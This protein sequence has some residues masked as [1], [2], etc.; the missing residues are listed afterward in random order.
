MKA[1]LRLFVG[2]VLLTLI[3]SPLTAQESRQTL[4]ITMEDEVGG[5]LVA[6]RTTLLHV[7][8]GQAREVA[9]TREG[10]AVFTGLEPGEYKLSVSAPGFRNLERTITIGTESPRPMRLQMI[11][12]VTEVVEVEELTR[13]AP[14]REEIDQN[15]D[16]VN[17]NDD[18]LVGIPMSIRGDRIVTFLSRFMNTAAGLPSIVID[19]HEVTRLNLPP[20][21]IDELVVNKN[22]YSAEYRRP[23]RAR[24]EVVSQ[25]GS[26]SHHHGDATLIFNNSV[27]S[28]KSP[29]V[30]EKPSIEEMVGEFGFSGPLRNTKGSFLFAAELGGDRTTAVV[31]AQ[32]LDGPVIGFVPE[33]QRE[34]FYTGRIDLSPSD[35]VDLSMR[36]EYES[37][38]ERNGGVGGLIL[39]ELARNGD[40]VKHDVYLT[41]S[42]ILSAGFIHVPSIRLSRETQTEGVRPPTGPMIIVQGA[43]EGGVL[44]RYKD[45][46]I[47]QADFVD[48]AT[49]RKG[50]HVVRFGGRFTPSTT[51]MSDL[52]DFGGRYE[53]ASLDL[54]REGKPYTFTL[55]E[56][57]PNI[58]YNL[59]TAD[60]HLQDEFKIRPDFT[61][62]AGVRWDWESIL[63][64]NNNVSPRLA[65]SFAPGSKKTAIRGGAGMFY[66]RVGSTAWERVNLYGGDAIRSMVFDNP[67]YPDYRVGANGVRPTPTRYQL[68][69]GLKAPFMSQ[70]SIG[71]DRQVSLESSFSLEFVHLRGTDLFRVRDVNAPPPGTTVRPD[72]LYNR[73]VEIET[74]GRMRSNSVHATFNGEVGEFEGHVLYTY[75]KSD[76]DTPGS[77][78]GGVLS[79]TLPGDSFNPGSEWGPADWDRKHRFSAAGVYELPKELSVGFVLDWMSGLPYEITTGFD[80]NGDGLAKDHPIGVGRNAGRNPTFFQLDMRVGKM[81]TSRRPVDQEEEPA[82]FELFI[83][84]FNVFNT[85]NYSDYVGVRSSPN[86]GL[87]TRAEKGRQLQA[88]FSYSF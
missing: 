46:E 52:N 17:V 68:A 76:N 53:F 67:T 66:E 69:Q 83:D 45:W 20:R 30:N 56:G 50:R 36:Y 5:V 15:A 14:E 25:D 29:F 28:A 27:V 85:I 58:R 84:V 12:E 6:V 8:S 24:I 11:V 73:V 47:L 81:W 19:G 70:G 60:A 35:R 78:A 44:Q 57:N 2:I 71:L 65:F 40:T 3:G 49:Y 86:F 72:P 82:E 59:H 80:D 16:Q 13:P 43:F 37:E 31:N 77:N 61:L 23:G 10:I 64:D 33:R 79:L 26:E 62:M 42:H 22:P 18:V 51:R 75:S 38:T 34:Q 7:A 4:R 74:S 48:M 87:P 39:P 9:T 54:Y 21:A 63:N 55:N 41:A 32:T 1:C 88:G